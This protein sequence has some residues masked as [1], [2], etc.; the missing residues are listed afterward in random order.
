[1]VDCWSLYSPPTP[2]KKRRETKLKKL[3]NEEQKAS[4]S[5]AFP[6]WQFYMGLINNLP[7]FAI[8]V[9]C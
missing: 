7:K 4:K 9:A 8:S 3:P 5:E 2:Q 6:H 1:M